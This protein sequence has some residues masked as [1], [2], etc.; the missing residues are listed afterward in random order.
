M[1]C[2]CKEVSEPLS[3]LFLDWAFKVGGISKARKIYSK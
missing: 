3:E 2:N 1:S